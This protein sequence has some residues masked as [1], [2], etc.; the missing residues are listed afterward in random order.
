MTAWVQS[1]E[2]EEEQDIDSPDES[3]SQGQQAVEVERRRG[4]ESGRIQEEDDRGWRAAQREEWRIKEAEEEK[5]AGNSRYEE[6]VSMA[7][8]LV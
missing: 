8:P 3:V 4:D 5:K 2:E 1:Q 6:R 7:T